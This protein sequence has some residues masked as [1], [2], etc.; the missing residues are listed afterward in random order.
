MSDPTA[1]PVLA[2]PPPGHATH[3]DPVRT[4][5][6]LRHAR[7]TSNVAGTLAGRLPGVGLDETGLAQAQQVAEQLA[8]VE[9]ARIVSSPAERCLA[10]LAPLAA[11]TGLTVETDDRLAEVDYG[12]WSGRKLGDLAKEDL[13]RVV[14]QR[15]SAAVFPDGEGLADVSARAIAAIRAL[16][17]GPVP[18]LVCSHGDVLKAILADALGI[19][20]DGFQRI[21]VAPASLSVVRYST[22]RP[23]VER[24]N[25]TSDLSALFPPPPPEAGASPTEPTPEGDAVVGGATR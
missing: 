6:L 18:V 22:A 11:A 20:L 7:S 1:T 13:W 9:I 8:G 3:A 19:H 16:A 23:M 14:Q 17:T 15:P 24:I 2:T 10:T 12:S 4:V 21:N 25:Q 5:L